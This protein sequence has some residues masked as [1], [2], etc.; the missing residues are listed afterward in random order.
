MMP[1]KIIRGTK[2]I[3]PKE[4]NYWQ[5]IESCTKE[6]LELAN[7][8]EIRTP[9]FENEN[10]FLKSIGE[11][12][13]IVS[14]EMYTFTDQGDRKITLRPEGTAGVIRSYIEN[15]LYLEPLPQRLWYYGPMFRY[16]R[17]QS[18]RQR[19]FYQ[20]GIE[21]IGSEDIR[22]DVE[23]IELISR[24]LQ[25]L[26]LNNFTLFINSV[27][28]FE[29]RENYKKALKEY[30]EPYKNSLD[31]DSQI[32]L[33]TNPLRILDSKDLTTQ[34]ILKESPQILDFLS[35]TSRKKFEQLCEY[36]ALLQ[37]NYTI[38]SKLVRGLDYYT[39][40]AFEIKVNTLGAQNTICGGGRY[41]LLVEQL[42]GPKTPAI[43]CAIG[44]ERLISI[45]KRENA[46]FSIDFHI[47][48]QGKLAKSKSL[49]IMKILR[50]S[51]FSVN[52]DLNELN[53]SKQVKKATKLGARACI[54]IGEKECINHNIA[55]KWLKAFQQESIADKE[56][57]QYLQKVGKY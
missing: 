5:N 6:I 57:E 24:I 33:Q 45:L 39:H 48:T 23:I 40:T 47:A 19:Q 18:G 44:I 41:D 36:L 27:G 3:L 29:D 22:A 8:K 52:L 1:I 30:L 55:I 11:N 2:D 35:Y 38:D 7:Y 37:I 25:K 15:K 20:L 31:N 16:E 9:T 17:P 4:A 34:E 54:F 51:G 28:S 56:F 43:G 26:E 42:G 46:N 21:C 14:K 53:F 32:R 49:T 50:D 10:L 13:D 12:T